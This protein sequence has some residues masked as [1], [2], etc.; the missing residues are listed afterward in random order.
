MSAS[1]DLYGRSQK[2][3]PIPEAERRLGELITAQKAT[4]GMNTGA[5]ETGINQYT[6]GRSS[7]TTAPKLAD[8][9]ISK[10]LSSRSQK[11]VRF[12]KPSSSRKWGKSRDSLI[13]IPIRQPG[14]IFGKVGVAAV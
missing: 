9:G 3:T 12:L 2:L 14:L 4:L 7:E 13:L 8:M 5:A 10:D 1:A 6:E 11:L